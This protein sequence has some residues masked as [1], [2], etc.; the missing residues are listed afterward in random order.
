M[1][2]LKPLLAFAAVIESGSMHAAAKILDVSASA[3]SQHITRLESIHGVKLLKRS[4]RQLAPTEAGAILA[5]HCLAL[6]QAIQNAKTALDNVKTQASG[7]VVISLP[8]SLVQAKVFQAALLRV[9]HELPL[10][11]IKLIVSDTLENLQNQNIDIALRGGEHALDTPNLVARHLVDWHY[12]LVTSPSYLK[13]IRL[14]ETV[15]D[16]TNIRWLT[17]MPMTLALQ[18]GS[19]KILWQMDNAWQIE[20]LASVL[21]MTLAGLGAS[22][23]LSGEIDTYLVRDELV[24]LLP[25]WTLPVLSLYA[26]TPHRVQSAKVAAVLKILLDSFQVA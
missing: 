23:Q 5:E 11:R 9:A 1:T 20:Q 6:R 12:Q 3:I 21:Q 26:V 25:D 18:R 14:P 2:D 10:I 19:E 15:A 16:L 8:S 17:A 13:T 22:A 7:E 4:T 24:A